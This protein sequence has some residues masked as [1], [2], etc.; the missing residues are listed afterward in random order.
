MVDASDEQ[1]PSG[2]A[3]ELVCLF[4]RLRITSGVDPAIGKRMSLRQIAKRS[5]FAGRYETPVDFGRHKG[6]KS[7][8]G[9][10][11]QGDQ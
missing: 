3:D 10:H 7:R 8:S 4:P 9:W 1:H 2:W 6:A 11:R 5:G